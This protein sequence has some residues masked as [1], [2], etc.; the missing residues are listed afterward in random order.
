LIKDLTDLR[1]SQPCLRYG[2]QYFRQCSGNG[3]DFGYS[4]DPGGVIAFSRILNDREV[5]VAINTSTT[6][7]NTVHVV[8]DWNLNPNGRTW[9][10]LLSSE[11]N[12]AAPPPT[13]THGVNRTVQ[14]TLQSMEAQVLG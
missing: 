6:Q 4:P 5:L 3:I 2:R 8:V 7:P 13:A 12:P 1:E 11:P 9:S 10:V 14:V